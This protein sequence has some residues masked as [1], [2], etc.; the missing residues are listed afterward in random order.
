MSKKTNL[1]H[2]R[3][4]LDELKN[5]CGEDFKSEKIEEAIEFVDAAEEDDINNKDEII[6]LKNKINELEKEIG[7]HE[8]AD[9]PSFRQDSVGLDTISWFL[10]KENMVIQQEVEEF[11]E[12]LK[13]KNGATIS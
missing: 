2:L 8:D 1:Q 6:S 5:P 7:Q 3:A 11:I 13:I 10:E 12:R 4:V 9:T